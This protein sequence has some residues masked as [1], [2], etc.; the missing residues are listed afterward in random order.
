MLGDGECI[1]DGFWYRVWKIDDEEEHLLK[2]SLAE[3]L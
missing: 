3:P 1:S 2:P